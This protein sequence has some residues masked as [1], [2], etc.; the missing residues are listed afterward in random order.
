MNV[1][2]SGE[3]R[4]ECIVHP[5][6]VGEP[7]VFGGN[8]YQITGTWMVEAGRPLLLRTQNTVDAVLFFKERAHR[9]FQ[10]AVIEVNVG[11]LMVG[12]G[13]DFARAAVKQFEAEFLLYGKP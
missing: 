11:D 5:I 10:R 8:S 13:E 7:G 4:R 1:H 2:G 9:V 3:V 6:I 12:D